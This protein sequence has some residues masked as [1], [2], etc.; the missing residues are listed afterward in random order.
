MV[1]QTIFC[2]LF[3]YFKLF[4][5]SKTVYAGSL[6]RPVWS[7][8]P[9]RLKLLASI[10]FFK[11]LIQNPT[12]CLRIGR[13][14]WDK[15]S[16]GVD[17]SISYPLLSL[18][19]AVNLQTY[20]TEPSIVRIED[21]QE[22]MEAKKTEGVRDGGGHLKFFQIANFRHQ[23]RPFHNSL[24]GMRLKLFSLQPFMDYSWAPKKTNL[25]H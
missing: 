24:G 14:H 2:F 9:R 22:T 3:F 16:L 21:E 12:W 19:S 18:L 4:F 10:F 13:Q 17:V 25:R 1:W 7:I 23:F 6:Y 11:S 20:R 5:R 8:D 15:C